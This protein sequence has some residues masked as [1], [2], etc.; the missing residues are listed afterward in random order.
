MLSCQRAT[1]LMSMKVEKPLSTGQN[2]ALGLHLTMCRGCRSFQK[3]MQTIH[4]A[5]KIFPDHLFKDP[6]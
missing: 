4:E 6:L 1:E 5:C 2:L 3:Q